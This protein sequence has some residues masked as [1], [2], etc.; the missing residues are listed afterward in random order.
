MMSRYVTNAPAASEH[1]AEQRYYLGLRSRIG[2]IFMAALCTAI[3]AGG[4]VFAVRSAGSY[5]FLWYS[6]SVC[7]L[8]DAFFLRLA[9]GN[10]WRLTTRARGFEAWSGTFGSTFLW[11]RVQVRWEEVASYRCRKVR[12]G[13]E[14][15]VRF[16][17]HA[18]HK[19]ALVIDVT[20]LTP[21]VEELQR[22]FKQATG[23][24]DD[25][26][27]RSWRLHKTELQ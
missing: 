21:P 23:L 2:Y 10:G 27:L 7:L 4:Y 20:G 22:A 12:G 19:K 16:K 15:V 24:N 5:S 11:R 18:R 25:D 13:T 3:A 17:P 9:V 26:H 14:L 6:S 1:E 8:V